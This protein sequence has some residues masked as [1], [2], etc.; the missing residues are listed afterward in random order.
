MRHGHRRADSYGGA[1][2]LGNKYR[3]LTPNKPPS[4]GINN[5]YLNN[6]TNPRLNSTQNPTT[7]PDFTSFTAPRSNTR[8]NF[9]S[10]PSRNNN[11][12]HNMYGIYNN[13]AG[14]KPIEPFNLNP[15]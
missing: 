1:G 2:A 9:Y 14:K 13:T 8:D 15:L 10:T 4:Y 11:T 5:P 3:A 7:N 12:S 6:N